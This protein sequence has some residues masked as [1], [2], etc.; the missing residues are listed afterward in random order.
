MR[1][2]GFHVRR[3]RLPHAYLL[4]YMQ[5]LLHWLGKGVA[6]QI[7]QPP[8]AA[9]AAGAVPGSCGP[10]P[11]GSMALARLP[12]LAWALLADSYQAPLC[13]AFAPDHIAVAILHLALRIAGVEVPGNRHSEL[14]WWQVNTF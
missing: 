13:L 5:A 4:H 2:L 10:P 3:L 12:G 14:A 1:L 6:H 7:V 11:V 8:V 9:T